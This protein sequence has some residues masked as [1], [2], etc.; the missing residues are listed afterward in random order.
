MALYRILFNLVE[1]GIKYNH[2]GGEVTIHAEEDG[3]HWRLTVADTG[4]GIQESDYP[5]LFEPFWRADGSRSRESGGAGLGLLIVKELV[6]Q[7][8]GTITVRKNS[9]QGTVFGLNFP[10]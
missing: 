9:P 8:E 6:G 1:N 2:E 7:M 5:L 4:C 10:V 3:S